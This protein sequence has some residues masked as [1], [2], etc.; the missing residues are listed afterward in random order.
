MTRRQHWLY[1]GIIGSFIPWAVQAQDIPF[2]NPGEYTQDYATAWFTE[3]INGTTKRFQYAVINLGTEALQERWTRVE[4]PDGPAI[5]LREWRTDTPMISTYEVPI[6]SQFAL[7]AI[8]QDT[9]FAPDGWSWR[10]IDPLTTPGAWNNTTGDARFDSPFRLL[11]WYAEPSLASW[12]GIDE[13]DESV[14]AR[15]AIAPT[16]WLNRDS[17]LENMTNPDADA[18]F[19]GTECGLLLWN[20]GCAGKGFGFEAVAGAI[21]GPDEVDWILVTRMGTDFFLES[22]PPQLG[23]PD[24]PEGRNGL[25]F[26]GGL[27]LIAPT[28]PVPEPATGLLMLSGLSAIWW[29]RRRRD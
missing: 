23:D 12:R 7:D 2:P 13:P 29:M 11:Q 10:L 16:T 15:I 24:L 21:L 14:M 26:N 4:Q 1:A 6:L 22:R 17:L 27:A 5:N 19:G 28:A 25:S 3:D 9:I 20:E 18:K 8:R